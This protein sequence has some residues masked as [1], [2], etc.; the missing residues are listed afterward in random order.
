MAENLQKR[1]QQLAFSKDKSK[2]S[3]IKCDGFETLLIRH[4]FSN[5]RQQ[6]QAQEEAQTQI[7]LPLRI[8]Q[9]LRPPH[10][11]SSTCP[12]VFLQT[13]TSIILLNVQNMELHE[14]ARLS[15]FAKHFPRIDLDSI[16][17]LPNR[18]QL[19]LIH[20]GQLMLFA[21]S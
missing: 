9:C 18:P 19:M 11:D 2:A 21:Y 7:S 5:K 17:F 15:T 8:H 6:K 16:C 14:L 4:S 13:Y 3:E 20:D 1:A 10:Y 12:F